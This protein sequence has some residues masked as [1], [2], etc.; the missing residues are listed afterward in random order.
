MST[1]GLRSVTAPVG[2]RPEDLVIEEVELADWLLE[3]LFVAYQQA[4]AGKRGTDDEHNF[5]I[6]AVENLIRLRDDIMLRQYKPS[7][8]IAFIS[9]EPVLREIFAAPFR[10][11]VVHHFLFN[12]VA[13]WWDRHFIYDS[14]SCR[15][16]K[17]TLFGIQRLAHHIQSV[18]ENYAKPAYVIK[19]DFK[20]FFMSLDRKKLFERACWGLDRQFPAQNDSLLYKLL[21]YLWGEIIFDDPTEGVERRGNLKLWDKLPPDKSLFCQPPGQGIVIG[22]LTSQLLSN[23]Y[24]SPFDMFCKN[25]LGFKHYGRYVDDA[26]YVVSEEE[27]PEALRKIPVIREYATGQGLM[28][29]PK[30][31]YVQSVYRGVPFLGARVYPGRIVPDRRISANF[32]RAVENYAWGRKPDMDRVLAYL[33]LLEHMKSGNLKKRVFEHVGWEYEF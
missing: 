25:E 7:R 19:T 21:K 3:Q 27:Y 11:R 20:G 22:N 26:F 32:M 5:E 31:L 13:A 18:T 10:D 9:V 29:H 30:K 1:G 6:N 2:Q 16:G 12:M 15:R 14:Y 23:V 33:G 8:G 17:G 28:L 4:R 24:L